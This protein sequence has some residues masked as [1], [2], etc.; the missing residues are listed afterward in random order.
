MSTPESMLQQ[1]VNLRRDK[2]YQQA[3]DL[4]QTSDLPDTKSADFY[5][6]IGY[7]YYR[8][9]N[10]KEAAKAWEKCLEQRPNDKN[11][12][13]NLGA[14]YND[15]GRNPEAIALYEKL[16]VRYPDTPSAWSNLAKALHD[17]NEHESSIYCYQQALKNQRNPQ[18][19]RG[20]ALAWRKVGR[21]DRSRELLEEALRINP[22]DVGAHF[23]MAMNCLYQEQYAEGT[24][25]FEWRLQLPKQL[26]FKAESP[27]LF[28][29]PKY[30]GESLKGKTLLVWT[31]QGFGDS[32]QYARFLSLAREQA[33]KLVMWCRPGLGRLLKANFP[34]DAV[35]EDKQ[36]L[37]AHDFQLSLMSLP[38][39][40]DPNLESLEKFAP[41]LRPVKRQKAIIKKTPKNK[42]IGLVWGA[43]QL[44]YEYANKKVPLEQLAPLF[45]LPGITWHSLQVGGDARDLDTFADA[46]KIIHHGDKLK[47]FA[48]TARAIQDLDLIISVD[49]SVTHLAGAMGKP[50]WVMLHKTADWRWHSD[51]GEGRWYPSSR[52][53]VQQTPNDWHR[54]ISL[55]ASH[56][57]KQFSNFKTLPRDK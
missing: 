51:S 36:D 52:L 27:T 14:C 41:Y 20:L 44:G 7:I 57:L 4:L 25:E 17:N 49:T 47:D 35:T 53:F 37:P 46:H 33:D 13:L 22:D 42:N 31:E 10:R 55:I 3:L 32:L 39:F 1:A 28:T 43:E 5:F 34:L 21:Y 38:Y 48:D 6:E 26:N 11:A 50:V 19:L 2:H 15:L 45:N 18:N 16:L 9:G 56:L 23:G 54:P 24:K 29:A 30:N 8:M 12:L 40:F